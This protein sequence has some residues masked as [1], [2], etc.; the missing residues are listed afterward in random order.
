MKTV[1]SAAVV[2]M[3]MPIFHNRRSEPP[4]YIAIILGVRRPAP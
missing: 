4:P 2:G 1:P 3:G